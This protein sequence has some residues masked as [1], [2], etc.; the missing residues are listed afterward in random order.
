[1][2]TAPLW[3]ILLGLSLLLALACAPEASLEGDG[4]ETIEVLDVDPTAMLT[5]DLDE[6]AA[7]QAEALIGVLPGDFPPDLP[8][9]QPA[10]L[11]DF[12]EPQSGERYVLL[13]TQSPLAQVKE[14]LEQQLEAQGWSGEAWTA[15][16]GEPF[17]GEV[18][19]YLK[20]GRLATVRIGR[21]EARQ[22][23]V[24]MDYPNLKVSG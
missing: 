13:S 15:S 17:A 5:P 16:E 7:E 20:D 12:A 3:P 18:A 6:V 23:L 4:L 19:R 11:I 24:R 2:G 8:V 21:N 1:M 22:T 9:Y 10:S 14:S